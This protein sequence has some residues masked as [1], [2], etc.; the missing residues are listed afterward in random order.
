VSIQLNDPVPAPETESVTVR[1]VDVEPFTGLAAAV[2]RFC[3]HLDEPA[4]SAMQPD[5]VDALA[6]IQAIMWR[7]EHSVP[8]T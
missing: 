4:I 3:A 7:L 2:G 5:A 6:V 1:L 8:E